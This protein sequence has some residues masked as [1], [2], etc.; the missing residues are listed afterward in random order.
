MTVRDQILAQFT[1]LPSI[2]LEAE[3]L[4][5]RDKVALAIAAGEEF[6]LAFEAGRVTVKI[7]YPVGVYKR[8]GR[9]VVLRMSDQMKRDHDTRE[10]PPNS[11]R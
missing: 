3:E 7:R 11:P 1:S 4:T 2:S 10:S 5:D 8:D 9:F 6:D